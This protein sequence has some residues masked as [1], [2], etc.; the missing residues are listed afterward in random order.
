[1]RIYY[2]N[3]IDANGAIFTPTSYDSAYPAD[4][5]S[6]EQRSHGWKTG[7]TVAAENVVIDLGAVPSVTIQSCILLD[8]DLLN[9]DSLIKIQGNATDS[10]GAPTVDETLTW[11]SGIIAK[12]FTGAALRYWRL[13]FTKASAGV[14]RHIGRLFLGPYYTTTEGVSNAKIKQQDLSQS[15]RTEGGQ[16]WSDAQDSFREYELPFDAASNSQVDSIITF[17]NAVGTFK[18]FF[19]QIDEN[20]ANAKLSE[21]VYAKLKQ[22]PEYTPNGFDSSGELAWNFQLEIEEQL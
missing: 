15:Q 20:S 6:N 11:A 18:S 7:A 22:K 12:N 9:T 5:L 4:L 17:A 19:F 16:K 1:M 10:W 2:D 8:H 13:L 14:Q 21:R 3:V